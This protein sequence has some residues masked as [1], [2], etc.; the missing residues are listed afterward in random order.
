MCFLYSTVIDANHPH[1]MHDVIHISV[2]TSMV[3]V[4]SYSHE[5]IQQSLLRPCMALAWVN[6][7]QLYTMYTENTHSLIAKYSN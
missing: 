3:G 5:S 2:T 1:C 6:T 7:V 4:A